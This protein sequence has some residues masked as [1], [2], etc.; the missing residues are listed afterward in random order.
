M[1]PDDISSSL[2]IIRI[3]NIHLCLLC[4]HA[5]KG[6]TIELIY[7]YCSKEGQCSDCK[8]RGVNTD[9]Y[10]SYN[11]KLDLQKQWF[12][13]NNILVYFHI[14]INEV[15]MSPVEPLWYKKNKMHK[16]SIGR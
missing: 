13:L 9:E 3:N 4:K 2:Q 15:S 10:V 11:V 8:G 16:Y 5:D 12:V 14:E 7:H 1:L 6:T